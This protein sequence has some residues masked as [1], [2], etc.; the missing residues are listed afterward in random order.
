MS[1]SNYGTFNYISSPK[2]DKTAIE[3]EW[4]KFMSGEYSQLNVRA[5]MYNSW[6]RCIEQGVDPLNSKASYTLGMDQIREYMT[7]HSLFRLVEPFL[8]KL[9]QL[10]SNTGY[11]VS[12]FNGAGEMI[13]YDGDMSLI[14][15]AEDIHFSPGSNWSEGNAGTNAIGTALV[16]GLPNQVFASEHFCQDFHSWTCSAAPIHDPATGKVLGIIDLTGFWTVN[17]L[18]ALDAVVRATQDIENMLYNHLKIE[19]FRLSQ[20]FLELTKRMTLPLAVLDRGGRVIKASQLLY[21][22]DWITPN[23][24]MKHPSLEQEFFPSKMTWEIESN[25]KMWLFELSPYYYGGRAI[26]SIVNVFPPDIA[27]FKNLPD[28]QQHQA[29][30]SS[31]QKEEAVE[32][33]RISTQDHFYKSLFVHH[34]DAIFSYNLQGILIEANP[35]AERMLGYNASELNNIKVQDLALPDRK[36][37]KLQVFTNSSNGL[38]QVWEA[39]LQHKQGHSLD[40]ELK[41]FPIIVENEIV[42]VYEIVRD[43]TLDH[44]QNLEDLR[45]AKEQIES[46]FSNADDAMLV[47]NTNLHI[48]KANKSF[49]RV[50]GWIEQELLGKELPMIPDHLKEETDDLRDNMRWSRY[51]LPYETV[52]QCKDGSLID[53]SNSAFPLFDSKGNAIAYVLISRDLTEL[54]R[55]GERLIEG[56]KRL[57]TLINSIPDLVIF[58]DDQGRWIEAN[59]NALASFQLEG[60]DYQGMTDNELAAS[61]EFYHDIYFQCMVSDHQAWE[62]GRQI[63]IQEIIPNPNGNSAI[64]DVIKIPIYHADGTRKGL[65]IIGRDITELKHT[66]ELLRKTEKLAVVGQLAAGIAHE[67]RNP[68][69]ALKGFLSLMKPQANDKNIRYLEVML[70]EIEQMEWI[71]NQFLTVSKPQTVKLERNNLETVIRQVSSFLF[72]LATMHN[73]QILIDSDSGEPLIECEENQLK[74]VF[75]NIVKNAIE[76]MPQ[77]GQIEIVIKLNTES[78]S[79]RVIDQGCGIP[80]DRLPHLGE[81][82]YSLKEKGTGLG[83]MICHKIIKEH[84]GTIQITSEMGRGTTVEII[85]PFNREML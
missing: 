52:S 15:K 68:L 26:G 73:V 21:E 83:L 81:P 43:I 44:Q 48:V 53:V 37:R 5:S 45:A 84:H 11:L 47:I 61:N 76:A 29:P 82:F 22:K 35:A 9:K 32:T 31:F 18:K 69:T 2:S 6:Q 72:P 57:R 27:S 59:D 62:E 4:E 10:A 65:I 46:F 1:K 33:Q 63:R 40:V 51:V 20:Y 60:T 23:H 24:R 12:Y 49:E 79:V 74:Q 50:F 34:P 78:V 30:S 56:E 13:Y 85:L 19:R 36:E 67:I 71:A 3:R 55:M 28:F 75:I 42:G 39:A 58:K 14:L 64:L 77:G 38:H 16:T 80:Q 70:S 25:N 17:D 66:E 54:K 7:S 41:S 8:K